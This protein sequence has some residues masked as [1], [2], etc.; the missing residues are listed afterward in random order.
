MASPPTLLTLS[1][2]SLSLSL[3]PL[4]FSQCSSKLPN[5]RLYSTCNSLPHLGASLL[6][7]FTPSTSLLS[8]AFSAPPS[9]PTGWVSW[10]LNPTSTGMAGSQALVAFKQPG[11]RMGVK[12]YN[13]TA[14]GP[15]QE[16][17]IGYR[18]SD[19]EAEYSGGVMW[20]FAKVELGRGE[21]VVNGVWQVGSSV[22]GGVP[23]KH[24]FGPENL[25]AKGRLDL[26]KGVSSGGEGGVDSTL[27]KKNVSTFFI[28]I[29]IIFF[30]LGSFFGN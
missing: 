4:S 15:I 11:G 7:T 24:E 8:L 14:Y 12:T 18:V 25:A 6:Y 5:N 9:G 19:L 1:L 20:I 22:V 10:A 21:R 3:I 28:V 29:I 23:A 26:V 16:G 17:P 30:S 13:I 27:K 2:L